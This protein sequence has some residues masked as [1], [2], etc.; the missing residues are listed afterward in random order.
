V[1]AAAQVCL[2]SLK[3]LRRKMRT[4]R[5]A[6]SIVLQTETEQFLT[7]LLIM[8]GKAIASSAVVEHLFFHICKDS[9]RTDSFIL[10]DVSFANFRVQN[11]KQTSC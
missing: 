4:K 7:D 11:G 10:S 5:P 2:P 1:S 6:L 9:L 3:V 8:C